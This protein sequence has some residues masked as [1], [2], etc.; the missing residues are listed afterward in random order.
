MIKLLALFLAT[1][2]SVHA[3]STACVD[4][5]EKNGSLQIQRL[6]SSTGACYLLVKNWKDDDMIFRSYVITNSGKLLIFSSYGPGEAASLTGAREYYH[7]PRPF[8]VPQFQWNNNTRQLE[9]T[10]VSGQKI[11]FDYDLGDMVSMDRAQLRISNEISARTKGGLE[12]TY[13]QGLM[14]NAG[15]KVGGAPSEALQ[16]LSTFTDG[17]GH[18]CQIRN[19]ELFDYANNSDV[20]FKFSDGELAAFLKSAALKFVS[21]NKLTYLKTIFFIPI[22]IAILIILTAIDFMNCAFAIDDFH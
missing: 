2:F 15:F 22:R 3:G 16:N 21:K 13:F 5:V 4:T 14:L 17:Q 19:K 9:V 1:Q 10:T 20:S 6:S 18:K 7:F 12:I 11:Y 8:A